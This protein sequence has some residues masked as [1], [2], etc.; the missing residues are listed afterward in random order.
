M[1]LCLHTE[2][3]NC[4]SSDLQNSKKLLS[5]LFF[6]LLK[7]MW[8]ILSSSIIVQSDTKNWKDYIERFCI[9]S[10]FLVFLSPVQKFN[11]HSLMNCWSWVRIFLSIGPKFSNK[12]TIKQLKTNSQ[13]ICCVL[14]WNII[15]IYRKQEHFCQV[16]KKCGF[17]TQGKKKKA[18]LKLMWYC[19]VT[20]AWEFWVSFLSYIGHFQLNRGICSDNSLAPSVL[21]KIFGWYQ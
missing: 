9:D 16:Q 5:N 3:G 17:H 12:K 10:K 13:T 21:C 15:L 6:P 4:F 8:D 2:P 19:G 20:L 1:A 7:C 11:W 14:L 18:K